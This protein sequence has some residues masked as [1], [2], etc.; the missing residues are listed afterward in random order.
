MVEI[1]RSQFEVTNEKDAKIKEH[2]KNYVKMK[3][4]PPL[5]A[6]RI[7]QHSAYTFHKIQ[8]HRKDRTE[9]PVREVKYHP[10][11]EDDNES[12]GFIGP[13]DFK[14]VENCNCPTMLMCIT[15][16]EQ[17]KMRYTIDQKK[18][19]PMY[20]AE[21]DDVPKSDKKED[22]LSIDDDQARTK[23]KTSYSPR[24]IVAPLTRLS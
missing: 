5:S 22:D 4:I 11:V 19:T 17:Y 20:E 15:D 1:K 10:E 24:R 6:F 23:I 8:I 12:V 9:F 13:E 21:K 3:G 2:N 18:G 16:Y 7:K 14:K